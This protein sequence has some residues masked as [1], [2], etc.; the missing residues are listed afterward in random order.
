ML[1]PGRGLSSGTLAEV[2]VHPQDTQAIG[3]KNMTSVVW[4]VT[5]DTGA[6]TTVAA[7]RSVKLVANEKIKIGAVTIDVQAV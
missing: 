3:L 6:T 5:L 2:T 4:T 1:F 7:G